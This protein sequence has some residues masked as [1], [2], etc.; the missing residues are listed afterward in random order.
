ML[1]I[2][3]DSD[4]DLNPRSRNR[5]LSSTPQDRNTSTN[6]FLNENL[7]FLEGS[8]AKFDE[9]EEVNY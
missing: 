3:N 7:Q 5:I 1:P 9:A 6:P 4:D 2:T 8:A